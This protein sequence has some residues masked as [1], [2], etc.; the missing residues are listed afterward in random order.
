MS[1]YI[2]DE[3]IAHMLSMIPQG[4]EAEISTYV[5]SMVINVI[6]Y[7]T[8]INKRMTATVVEGAE[9]LYQYKQFRDISKEM[10]M[11]FSA[12]NPPDVGLS[13][14]EWLDSR[15]LEKRFK[16]IMRQMDSF[17]TKIIA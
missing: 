13:A 15:G 4:K 17:G 12:I 2:R 14:L 7:L 5:G 16:R 8:I 3:E 11:C 1:Q 9:E 6:S 10:K